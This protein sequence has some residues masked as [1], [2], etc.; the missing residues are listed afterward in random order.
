MKE[1]FILANSL[2]QVTKCIFQRKE[3]FV[4]VLS[5]LAFWSNT[6]FKSYICFYSSGQSIKLNLHPFTLYFFKVLLNFDVHC[7]IFR[8]VFGCCAPQTLVEIV[9]IGIFCAKKLK[10]FQKINKFVAEFS[11]KMSFLNL[12]QNAGRKFYSLKELFS[13]F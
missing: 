12:H 9:S 2:E 13:C 6:T 7:C 4:V 11:K 8:P 10:K 1:T 5:Y 3:Y